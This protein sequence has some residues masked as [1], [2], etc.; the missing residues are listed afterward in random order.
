MC[1]TNYTELVMDFFSIPNNVMFS[2][3]RT[4]IRTERWAEMPTSSIE[5]VV[6]RAFIQSISL[7]IITLTLQI[8][9]KKNDNIKG[10]RDNNK[11]VLD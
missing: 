8:L 5:F 2:V 3:P 6:H 4:E 7:V 1:D 10:D 9:D 11:G